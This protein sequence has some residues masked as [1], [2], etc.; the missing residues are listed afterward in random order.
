MLTIFLEI[1]LGVDNI[2]FVSII[3]GKISPKTEMTQ[4]N[5]RFN[6]ICE[7]SSHLTPLDR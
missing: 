4:T 3:A 2:L 5:H 6:L 7:S 1:V